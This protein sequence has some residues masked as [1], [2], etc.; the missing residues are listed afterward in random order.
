MEILQFLL[1]YFL[2]NKGLDKLA[3][4]FELLKANSFDLKQVLKNLNPSTLEP[5]LDIFMNFQNKKAPPNNSGAFS[6]LSPVTNFA[7][8][9]IVNALNKYFA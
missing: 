4:L 3:P 7:D 6:G 8:K 9:E 2:K 5:L 1:S